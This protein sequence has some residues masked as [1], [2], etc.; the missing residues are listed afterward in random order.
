MSM[1]MA[2]LASAAI[3]GTPMGDG[4]EAIASIP[5]SLAEEL[6]G[7]GDFVS[8]PLEALESEAVET[9][10]LRD[11]GTGPSGGAFT[12]GPAGGYL[13][14]KGTD[15]GTWFAGAQA[16]FH[17][18]GYFA[19]EGAI[20]FHENSYDH[21]TVHVTQYPVQVSG[22]F[23]PIP[24]GQFQPYVV[25]GVGWY[26]TRITYSG[27]LSDIS[28]QTE[29]KFGGHGGAGLEILLGPRTSIDGDIRYIFVSPS[30]SQVKSG[31]FDYWQVTF[32]V[33][34]IF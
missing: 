3:Y 5:R 17:F 28:N 20:T 23:Y 24:G 31:D 8:L 6:P 10:A 18:L 15:R 34:F 4:D 12:L 22:M 32:G 16:R 7:E 19:A 9:P 33:N 14:A 29:H 26:Y 25:G 21:G 13:K 1:W 27:V 30:S 2:L 11:G